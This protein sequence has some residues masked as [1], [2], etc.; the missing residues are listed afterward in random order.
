M[1]SLHVHAVLVDMLLEHGEELCSNQIQLVS[2]HTLER[3]EDGTLQ[4]VEKVEVYVRC[5]WIFRFHKLDEDDEDRTI[6]ILCDT[7]L[8]SKAIADCVRYAEN[9]SRADP[10]KKSENFMDEK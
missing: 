7:S 2:G 8:V 3:H 4:V 6:V 1:H 10:S 5:I 9:T